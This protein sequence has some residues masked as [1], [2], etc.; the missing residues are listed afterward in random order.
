MTMQDLH[1]PGQPDPATGMPGDGSPARMT[2]LIH[3]GF[4]KTGSTWLQRWFE[5]HP[6][7]VFREG[8]IGGYA[9]VLDIG[10]TSV[11]RSQVRCRVTS[12]EGLVTRTPRDVHGNIPRGEDGRIDVDAHQRVAQRQCDVCEELFQLFPD[13]HI[14]IVTRGLESGLRSGFGEMVRW[15]LPLTATEF[16]GDTERLRIMLRHGEY[17][18]VV[19]TYRRRFGERVLVMPYELLCDDP[20]GFRRAIEDFVGLDAFEGPAAKVNAS[21]DP[22]ELRWYPWISKVIDRLPVRRRFRRALLDRHLRAIRSGRWKPFLRVLERL[23]G[24]PARGVEVPPGICESMRGTADELLRDA[25]Y[26]PYREAYLPGPGAV[27]AGVN[28]RPGP[29]GARPVRPPDPG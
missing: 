26:A 28:A 23:A 5:M 15:G 13:A 11:D 6:Q 9:S 18:R 7:I 1:V 3:V 12:Y 27:D 17:D 24:R 29:E 8:G 16:F 2:H 20:G 22:D 10:L 14:L 19:A 21:L 4:P 25:R